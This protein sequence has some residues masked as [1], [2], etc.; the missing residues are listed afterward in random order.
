MRH[1]FHKISC[2]L[3]GL[4]FASP[5]VAC[6][7]FYPLAGKADGGA[8]ALKVEADALFK[9][10]LVKPD[11]LATAFRFAE[12]ETQ[13]GDYEAAIGALER[14]LFYNKDLPR[15]RLELGVLYFRLGSY[16]T[17]RTSLESALAGPKVPE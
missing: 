16:G 7:I 10:I 15:V 11:D 13:L 3:R 4:L 5:V 14:M 8:E 2:V 1:L 9:R 17:A 6:A 12:I